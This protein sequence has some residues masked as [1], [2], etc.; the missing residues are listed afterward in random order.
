MKT[1]SIFLNLLLATMVYSQVT[2]VSD[3]LFSYSNPEQEHNCT[4]EIV[5]N[6]LIHE[7]APLAFDFGTTQFIWPFE[8]ELDEEFVLVNYVDHASGSGV[9]DYMGE[10]WTYNGHNGT[11]IC[12]HDFRHMDRFVA[13]KA[14]EAGTIIEIAYNNFDR[15][16]GWD[17]SPA[18]YVLIRHEDGNYAYYFHLMR[19]SV[20]VKVG[21]YVP[22]GRN[23]G[24]V[25]SSGNFNGCTPSF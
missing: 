11:D 8:N 22:Q 2:K 7:N 14:A 19:K 20:T 13:V 24:Y 3:N 4:P 21:E 9:Q 5:F 1:L 17:N 15:N 16:T 18:N 23:I 6:P 12:L 10:Q 25:G